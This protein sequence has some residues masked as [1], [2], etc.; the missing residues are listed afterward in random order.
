[1][2]FI[3][4]IWYDFIL[5]FTTLVGELSKKKKIHFMTLWTFRQRFRPL[6]RN[7]SLFGQKVIQR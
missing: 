5:F 6:A 2:E 3:V 4:G 1:M 7:I